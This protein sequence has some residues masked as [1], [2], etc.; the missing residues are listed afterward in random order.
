[1]QGK[2]CGQEGREGV[3]CPGV[4]ADPSHASRIW[5]PARYPRGHRELE[6]AVLGPGGRRRTSLEGSVMGPQDQKE[7][8]AWRQERGQQ[9]LHSRL[10]ALPLASS[11]AFETVDKV[12]NK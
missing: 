11:P 8:T 3:L 9:F 6:D 12:Y 1:M 7:S 5:V 2:E 4:R 10:S